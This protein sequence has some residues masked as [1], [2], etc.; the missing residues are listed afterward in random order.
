[1]RSR[2]LVPLPS[3]LPGSAGV[4]GPVLASSLPFRGPRCASQKP[5]SWHAGG[6]QKICTSPSILI[7]CQSL[8]CLKIRD[9]WPSAG[10]DFSRGL[11]ENTDVEGPRGPRWPRRPLSER[12]HGAIS[13]SLFPL[14]CWWLPDSFSSCCDSCH[15]REQKA[16]QS[17]Q[18]RHPARGRC[19]GS[20]NAAGDCCVALTRSGLLRHSPLSPRTTLPSRVEEYLRYF[21]D[22]DKIVP[23]YFA[24]FQIDFSRLLMGHCHSLT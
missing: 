7:A 17:A 20:R 22:A 9:Q 18:E 16:R 3:R 12:F 14:C 10:F 15:T 19:G 11:S 4:S 23:Q 1:M 24:A 2:P 13:L 6:G 5:R 8:L 21:P